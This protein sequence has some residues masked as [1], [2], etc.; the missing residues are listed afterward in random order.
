MS[1]AFI[2][3]TGSISTGTPSA[4][5]HSVWY[6]AAS[7]GIA[8]AAGRGGVSGGGAFPHGTNATASPA[9]ATIATTAATHRRPRRGLP[10]ESSAAV[11]SAIDGRSVGRTCVIRRASSS[12]A[13]GTSSRTFRSDNGVSSGGGRP[14]SRKASVRPR[15]YTSARASTAAGSATCS[16]AMYPGVPTT[17]ASAAWCARRASPTS[18]TRTTPAG[19]RIRFDGFTSRWTTPQPCA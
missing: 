6:A 4:N 11:S 19:V 7:N 16:G 2:P 9:T 12:S 18:S 1:R 3:G 17:A 14:T 8:R 5:A 15:A 10:S 13:R